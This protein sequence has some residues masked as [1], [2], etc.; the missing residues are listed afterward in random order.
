MQNL[1]PDPQRFEILKIL[2]RPL[3][4]TGLW[5][6]LSN[7]KTLRK[8]VVLKVCVASKI[9]D[10]RKEAAIHKE[11]YDIYPEAVLELTSFLI[12]SN[13]QNSTG[14]MSTPFEPLGTLH[15]LLFQ[16]R[17]KYWANQSLVPGK[18]II[19]GLSEPEV[20]I[21][22]KDL[23]LA[24]VP[25]HAA[26]IVHRDVKLENLILSANKK[27]KDD[28]PR[29]KLLDFGLALHLDEKDPPKSI[30]GT[31][32]YLAPEMILGKGYDFK[33]DCWS[34][35]IA[36][37]ELVSGFPPFEGYREEQ[38]LFRAI[39]LNYFD[40]SQALETLLQLKKI[41]QHL[42]SFISFLLEKNPAKRPCAAEAL[43]HPWFQSA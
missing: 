5:I 15:E 14:I 34:A 24:L 1:T 18:K 21:H 26:G 16:R 32:D 10:L 28:R 12:Y 31:L 22:M 30:M 38:L 27:N 3:D 4:A 33:V 29:L 11:A 6:L 41:S 17:Q 19:C 40:E 23:F 42:F 37:F 35:G 13:D 39:T 43:A 7:D 2:K 20:K 36:L 25:L 8:R 9:E